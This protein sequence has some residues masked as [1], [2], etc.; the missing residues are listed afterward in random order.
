MKYVL[1]QQIN[2]TYT[3]LDISNKIHFNWCKHCGPQLVWEEKI[4]DH[5]FVVYE[6]RILLFY[7]VAVHS[8][9]WT[10]VFV[11]LSNNKEDSETEEPFSPFNCRFDEII[12]CLWHSKPKILS[13]SERTLHDVQTQIP[14]IPGCVSRFDNEQSFI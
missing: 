6:E 1:R 7:V 4:Q 3:Y 13:N 8:Q 5:S 11:F 12:M 2:D 10:I 9:R 14:P